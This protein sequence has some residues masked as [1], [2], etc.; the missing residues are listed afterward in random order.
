MKFW[1]PQKAAG[2]IKEDKNQEDDV[3][4]EPCGE[5]KWEPDEFPHYV[6]KSM[7]LET[8][9][10]YRFLFIPGHEFFLKPS[11]PCSDFD[12]DDPEWREWNDSTGL[13]DRVVP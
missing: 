7:R 10:G 12:L 11:G 3:S 8:V 5:E 6:R 2:P 4:G 1:T 9:N 13:I